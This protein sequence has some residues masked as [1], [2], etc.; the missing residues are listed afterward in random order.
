M[1]NK[2]LSD[3]FRV[4]ALIVKF[5][6]GQLS[7]T[8]QAELDSWLAAHPDNQALL[9]NMLDEE[10]T[11]HQISIM[12]S[13]D[14]EN[15]FQKF[16]DRI[17]SEQPKGIRRLLPPGTYRLA[18]AAI[19]LIV[20]G[21]AWFLVIRK[22]N[23]V[24]TGQSYS[25]VKH[26][27]G[28]VMLTLANG[29]QV[30]VAAAKEGVIAREAGASVSKTDIGKLDYQAAANEAGTKGE[31]QYNTLTVPRGEQYEMTL[32]DGSHVWLNSESSLK[33]PVTFKADERV[34][35]LSGEAYFEVK[36]NN[37]QPFRVMANDQTV[38][39]LGTHFNIEAYRDDARTITTLTQGLVRVTR[40]TDKTI[41]KPGQ[42]AISKPGE[43]LTVKTANIEETLA[44]R[45]G[46]FSFNDDRVEDMMKEIARSYDVE[47]AYQ[48]N[49][50]DIKFWGTFPR[51]KGLGALLKNL[52][53]THTIHFKLTGR[54]VL[55]MP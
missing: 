54:R 38:E 15:A 29:K 50:K 31:L 46:L 43:A 34:V 9:N 52:E 7:V 28:K 24:H 12:S 30:D 48:G 42:L 33:F 55:V 27:P 23:P 17:V 3:S 32:P 51:S 8:E 2:K 35:E 47:I 19:L 10:R 39:V 6:N 53:Q 45:N 4:S 44:W 13:F 25:A 49:V 37:H 40:G 20:F 11:G 14:A 26:Q 1:A 22:G 21:A 16:Q 36:H 41:I 18:A 5:I